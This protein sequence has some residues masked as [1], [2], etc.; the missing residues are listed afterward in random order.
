MEPRKT[1][2]FGPIYKPEEFS[3]DWNSAVQTLSE[4]QGGEIPG[5]RPHPEIGPIDVV[6]GNLIHQR[7]TKAV[8][9]PKIAGKHP[10]V[11]ARIPELLPK[12]KITQRSE[13]RIRLSDDKKQSGSSS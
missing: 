6:G 10:E 4:R 13:N 2:Q 8:D 1:G 7:Q 12:M 11:L 9:C 3:G 5:L